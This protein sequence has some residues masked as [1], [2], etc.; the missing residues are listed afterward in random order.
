MI[1]VL[2]LIITISI[3]GLSL[4]AASPT[5][6]EDDN[7]ENTEE[8]VDAELADESNNSEELETVADVVYSEDVII[9]KDNILF[10]ELV[11]ALKEEPTVI[12]VGTP[13]ELEAALASAESDYTIKLTNNIEYRK[14]IIID[15]KTITFDVGNFTLDVKNSEGTGL[16]VINGGN[17]K[18]SGSG[19]L[20]VSYTGTKGYEGV[21]VRENSSATVT[22]VTS[23]SGSG[24]GVYADG[25]GAFI[26]VLGNIEAK[27]SSGKGILTWRG[28][29]VV[30]DGTVTIGAVYV[31]IGV[32]SLQEK[33]GVYDSAKPGYLKYIS[34]SDDNT[35]T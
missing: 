23:K 7:I 22:N 19:N 34:N 35:E 3:S 13:E 10:E 6:I 15:G 29:S 18:L 30:V 25:D 20:N 14:G 31:Q 9:Q 12:Q 21:K 11:I 26:R 28:G 27:G 17:V 24:I 2:T 8:V 16:N 4:Y 32:T 5:P 33:E 1:L